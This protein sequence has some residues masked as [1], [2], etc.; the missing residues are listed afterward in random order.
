MARI[1]TGLLLAGIGA[2]LL[3]ASTMDTS[4]AVRAAGN[5]NG[6]KDFGITDVPGR[7]AALFPGAVADRW[8]RL[9]NPQNF[10]IVVRTVSATVRPP[11]DASGRPAPGCPASSVSVRSLTAPVPVPGGGSTD[12]ALV[13]SMLPSAPDRCRNLIFPLTYT[14]TATKS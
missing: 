3:A 9:S 4:A 7:S 5:A 2:V 13:T 11:V 12:V 10:P 14:G 1:H 6:V 8:I